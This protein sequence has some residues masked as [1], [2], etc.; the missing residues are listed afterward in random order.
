MEAV[1]ENVFRHE[2]SYYTL[3][4][5]PGQTV[6]G[7]DIVKEDGFEYR[8]WD[9]SRSK[10]GAFLA[11]VGSLPVKPDMDILY[12]GAGD[13]TT[14]SHLSD[15]LTHGSIYAVEMARNPYRNLISLSEERKNIFPILSDA[16]KI[17]NYQDIVPK[18]DLLYQD[19]SQRDQVNI[20]LKNLSF[21]KESKFGMIAVK[22]RSI[23][24]SKEPNHIYRKVREELESEVEVEKSVKLD[25]WQKDH[26]IFVVEK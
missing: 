13:G 23:D 25:R 24:V 2:G 22:S 12:L 18:V 9:P 17:E 14:V 10:I 15:I 21:L 20:F 11:R 7:E 4:L 26:C 19:I 3:S 5:T 6:Y 1:T 8:H 16:R